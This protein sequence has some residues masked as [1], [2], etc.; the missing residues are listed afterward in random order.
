[1]EPVLK[2]RVRSQ[3][4]ARDLARRRLPAQIGRLG[5]SNDWAWDAVVGVADVP[6]A[7]DVA[8][9]VEVDGVVDVGWGEILQRLSGGRI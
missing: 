7:Q 1:M 4:E 6:G 8:D 9:D 2:V 3:G 5:S